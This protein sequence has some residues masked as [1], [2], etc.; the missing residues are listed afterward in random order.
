MA[1]SGD[2]VADTVE[3]PVQA[4]AAPRGD[5]AVASSMSASGRIRMSDNYE[6][7][8][9]LGVG[10]SGIVYKAR[11]RQLDRLVA[12]KVLRARDP[13]DAR[14]LQREAQTQARVDHPHI[15]KVYGVGTLA[16]N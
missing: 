11:D 16:F 15:C 1:S 2:K 13:D 8:G 6:L 7:L 14:R 12:L 9:Q 3:A 4:P 5:A 10:G